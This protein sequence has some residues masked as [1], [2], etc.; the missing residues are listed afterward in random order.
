MTPRGKI[1]EVSL[2]LKAIHAQEDKDAARRKAEE[3]VRKLK[4]LRLERAAR[5]VSEGYEETLSYYD[6]PSAH[7]RHVR[8]NNPLERLNREIRRRTRVVG[9]FPDGHAALMLVSARLRYMAGQRWG[10]QRYLSMRQ[11][12]FAE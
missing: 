5:V 8:T 6:F 10:T 9:S 11:T 3:V 2:M 7:W 4:E 1:R 12:E